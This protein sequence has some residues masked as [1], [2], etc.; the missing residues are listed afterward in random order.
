MVSASQPSLADCSL[1]RREARSAAGLLRFTGGSVELE[2]IGN[3]AVLD[4]WRTLFEDAGLLVGIRAISQYAQDLFDR[5]GSRSGGG[6]LLAPPTASP[7]TIAS[8][9]V[10]AAVISGSAQKRCSRAPVRSAL[11]H[12]TA[13]AEPQEASGEGLYGLLLVNDQARVRGVA[14]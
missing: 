10:E 4:T 11:G 6:G 13:E 2:E 3:T 12:R 8:P 1:L 7:A 14:G 9:S 5:L